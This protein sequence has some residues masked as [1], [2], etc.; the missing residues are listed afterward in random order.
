M[1]IK[2]LLFNLFLCSTLFAQNITNTLGSSGTFTIK[3]A[4][5]TYFSLNQS[6]GR[7]TLISPLA[8]NQRGSIFKGVDRFLHTYNGSGTTGNN[9]FVGI[10]SGN[11][12]MG[13]TIYQGSFNTGVGNLSLF[14][15]TTGSSNSAFGTY[16]LYANTTGYENSAFGESSLSTNTTGF[17]NSAFGYY[18]LHSNTTGNGNS[19]FG[20]S[21][22][23]FNTTG[24][25]NSAF[26]FEALNYNT[27]GIYNSAFGFISLYS[28]T[29]GFNNSA[30]GYYSL[31]RNTEGWNNS[32]FGS[33]TLENNTTGTQNSAFGSNSLAN[34]TTGFSNTAFGFRAGDLIT[35]GSNNIAI[36]ILAQVPSGTASNQI[37]LGNTS[38]TYAGIQVAW[39][40]T[41]DRRL[42]NNIL[43][44][45][46]GLSFINKLRPVSYTRI[47]DASGKTEY[48]LIAQEVEDALKQENTEN[49]GM[50]TVTDEGEYQLRYN[51]LLAPMIKAIQELKLASDI[52]DTEIVK[53]KYEND[54]LKKKFESLKSVEDRLTVL[55][56]YMLEQNKI[57]EVNSEINAV[58]Q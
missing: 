38:I 58:N 2:I 24:L 27:T 9:T 21:S 57:K 49:T 52:K 42:K 48:G 22:L 35:T 11:F 4:S 30:F 54:E 47:N 18:S 6:N 39:T 26:G 44:S 56:K 40:V 1:K 19:A 53:L 43:N 3:D 15:L 55:E 12:T 41:S 28:N 20:L 5:N 37:R 36:G 23:R 31:V 17:R 14:S 13:G 33:Y 16:S 32:A 8:G 10:N 51:D 34:N 45:N 46:L 50:L 29:T 25:N 7:L